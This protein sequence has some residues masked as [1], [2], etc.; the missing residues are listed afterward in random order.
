MALNPH[1]LRRFRRRTWVAIAAC[2]ALRASA[3]LAGFDPTDPAVA[4]SPSCSPS[5]ETT[6]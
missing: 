1:H 2:V 5:L 4:N 3:A 6:S